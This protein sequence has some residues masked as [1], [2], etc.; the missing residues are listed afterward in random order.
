MSAQET[1]TFSVSGSPRITV[2]TF[3]GQVKVHGWDKPEVTYTA[4]KY[5]HDEDSLRQISIQAQQQGQ[6][7]S[8][9]AQCENGDSN[10]SVSLDVYVPRQSSV[11]V[12]SGDGALNLEE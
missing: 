12:S 4:T 2:T 8:V 7:I 10:G 5:A 3:D 11:H 6:A 9:N 1:K